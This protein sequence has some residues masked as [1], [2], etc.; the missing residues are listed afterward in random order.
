MFGYSIALSGL[1][2]YKLGADTMKEYFSHGSRVWADYGARHPAMRMA[3]IFGIIVF[4][5]LILFDAASSTF[6]SNEYLSNTGFGAT[7]NKGQ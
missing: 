4:G 6:D 7:L 3:I 5:M 2:Y 1:V